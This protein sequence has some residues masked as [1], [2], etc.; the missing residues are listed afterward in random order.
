MNHKLPC[1]G[2]IILILSGCTP[3]RIDTQP[4]Q[5]LAS[6]RF[7]VSPASCAQIINSRSI[8]PLDIYH[9]GLCYEQG[10]AVPASTPK[11]VEHYQEA[12]R[13]GV[14]EAKAALERLGQAVPK[15]ELQKQQE[16]RGEQI[17]DNRHGTRRIKIIQ[18]Q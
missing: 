14:P 3:V 18:P 13:W 9:A 1:F 10:V 11:A 17:E 5:P 7:F 8:L 15:A 4:T 16:R 2:I 12:A 6:S